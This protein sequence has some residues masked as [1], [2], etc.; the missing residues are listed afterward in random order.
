MKDK[1][2]TI[3]LGTIMIVIV[4]MMCH[5]QVKEHL[6]QDDPMLDHLRIILLNVHPI[7][8]TLKLYK[9]DKSYTLNKEKIFLC[10]KDD[11]DKYY[12]LNMLIYVSL[13]EIAHVLSPT[14]GHD[15]SFY[16]EFE[17]LLTKAKNLGIYTDQ[18][19]QVKN[20]RGSS[21]G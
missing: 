3:T 20:Y 5:N 12:S 11:N 19:P 21:E 17:K 2:F 6:L 16:E 18:I 14:T 7:V 9:G 1:Y 10:L 15:H 4:Y 13:H 8:K